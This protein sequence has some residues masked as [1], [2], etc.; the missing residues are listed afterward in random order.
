M[1]TP[2]TR[3]PGWLDPDPLTVEPEPVEP[4][5]P[6][7]GWDLEPTPVRHEFALVGFGICLGIVLFALLFTVA[8]SV[9]AASR[10]APDPT[11]G[12]PR[13]LSGL[14]ADASDPELSG[15]PHLPASEPRPEASPTGEVGTALVGGYAT[16]YDAACHPCAAAGPALREFVGPDWRGS[17][18]E[19][20]GPAGA[21]VSVALLDWCACGERHGQPTL[22][23]LDRRSFARL[24]APTAG[25]VAIS[26][27][28]GNAPLP[29]TDTPDQHPADP[30]EHPDDERMRLEVRDEEIYR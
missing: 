14:L 15:A 19:V 13:D 25:L 18:V 30:P 27:E 29:R 11:V 26:I 20:C 23:D 3:P 2:P 17:V 6:Y 5:V 7:H 4:R 21:C 24:A 22:L 28:I 12:V 1:S 16:W 9:D 8:R 10:S